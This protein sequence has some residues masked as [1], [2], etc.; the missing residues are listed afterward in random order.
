MIEPS[1][2]STQKVQLSLFKN[3]AEYIQIL[4]KNDKNETCY[5]FLLPASFYNNYKVLK[6]MHAFY[7]WKPILFT[8][9][10]G[11]ALFSLV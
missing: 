7:L 3:Y 5:Q 4:L 10:F 6:Y 1:A 2:Q 9:T 11:T 8:V